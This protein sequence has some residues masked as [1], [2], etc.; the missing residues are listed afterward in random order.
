M[1]AATL[2]PSLCRA[3]TLL[4]HSYFGLCLLV[5]NWNLRDRNWWYLGL[6]HCKQK[7]IQFEARA[8]GLHILAQQQRV[9]AREVAIVPLA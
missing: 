3:N 1:G 5:Y 7:S 9:V 8:E 6:L 2:L 4:P